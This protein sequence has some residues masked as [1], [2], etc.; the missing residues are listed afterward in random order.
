MNLYPLFSKK[1]PLL[2]D[3]DSTWLRWFLWWSRYDSLSTSNLQFI[4][5][6][7]LNIP[8]PHFT[9]TIRKSYFFHCPSDVVSDHLRSKRP[10]NNTK[11]NVRK[12]YIAYHILIHKQSPSEIIQCYFNLNASDKQIKGISIWKYLFSYKLWQ[13]MIVCGTV[14]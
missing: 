3:H 1:D 10:K 13:T 5:D 4:S 8:V 7:K 11:F 6:P 2:E 9:D 14:A 12:F